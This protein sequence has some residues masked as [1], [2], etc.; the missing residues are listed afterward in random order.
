M[1][2]LLLSHTKVWTVVYT[3]STAVI[4]EAGDGRKSEISKV[5]KFK[6][7]SAINR[8]L[9]VERRL[10]HRHAKLP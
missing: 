10:S 3:A 4:S 5:L 1:Y 2:Y 9:D 8:T 6:W 7:L